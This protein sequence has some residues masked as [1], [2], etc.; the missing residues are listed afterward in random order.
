MLDENADVEDY[1]YPPPKDHRYSWPSQGARRRIL[2]RWAERS[3]PLREKD[4][5]C[6]KYEMSISKLILTFDDTKKK[7]GKT[8]KS[9]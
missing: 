2:F 9:R 3:E 5:L 7:M 4:Q 8:K 1:T 6:D